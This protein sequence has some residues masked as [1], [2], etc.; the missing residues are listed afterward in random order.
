VPDPHRAAQG[1]APTG[2]AQA[3]SP[4]TLS[5]LVLITSAIGHPPLFSRR[6]CLPTYLPTRAPT[7]MGR[8]GDPWP[9]VMPSLLA[10]GI[11]A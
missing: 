9:L 11:P 8:P 5:F 2:A 4:R 1:Q 3:L 7:N 6:S 10:R